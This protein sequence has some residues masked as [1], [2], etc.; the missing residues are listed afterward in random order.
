MTMLRLWTWACR[1]HFDTPGT[2]HRAG[3]PINVITNDSCNS[4]CAFS[5]KGMSSCRRSKSD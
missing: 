2:L 3:L 1:P 4:C 5:P